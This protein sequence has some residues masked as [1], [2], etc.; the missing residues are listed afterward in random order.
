M[1]KYDGTQWNGYQPLP[2]YGRLHD[3]LQNH[4]GTIEESGRSMR[5]NQDILAELR[6]IQ[7]RVN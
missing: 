3:S 7:R 1:N 4:F 2:S 5:M 6:E